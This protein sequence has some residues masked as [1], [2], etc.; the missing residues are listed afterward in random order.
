MMNHLRDIKDLKA[1]LK[2]IEDKQNEQKQKQTEV[3]QAFEARK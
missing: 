1:G 2:T 3:V